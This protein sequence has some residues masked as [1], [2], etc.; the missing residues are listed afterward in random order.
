MTVRDTNQLNIIGT[1][2]NSGG[3]QL[4]NLT[5]TPT[6]KALYAFN[7]TSKKFAAIYDNLDGTYKVYASTDVKKVLDQSEEVLITTLGENYNIKKIISLKVNAVGSMFM[8]FTTTDDK[9]RTAMIHSAGVAFKQFNWHPE[10][11]YNY[12]NKSVF[13]ESFA[14]KQNST[15]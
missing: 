10:T 7:Y 15:Y 11:A 2:F 4:A 9:N 6:D 14:N 12:P 13:V 8:G 3:T 1:T 5:I